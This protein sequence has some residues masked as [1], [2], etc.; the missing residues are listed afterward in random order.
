[1]MSKLLKVAIST[2]AASNSLTIGRGV[3]FRGLDGLV[4]I[5]EIVGLVKDSD[6][7]TIV[8]IELTDDE[9]EFAS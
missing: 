1:M 8:T 2:E 7:F 3:G 9:A 4:P 6:E 5:G